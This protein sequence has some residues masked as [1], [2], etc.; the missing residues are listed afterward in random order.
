MLATIHLKEPVARLGVIDPLL[1]GGNMSSA[2][3][4]LDFAQRRDWAHWQDSVIAVIRRDFHDVLPNL[5][6]ED[7]DWDAWR[8]LFDEGR[9]P[10][11]AVSSALT[12]ID[13]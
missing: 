4:T 5:A 2:A 3:N 1:G 10:E 11:E 13:G 6:Q 9:T 12:R 8:P 7:I